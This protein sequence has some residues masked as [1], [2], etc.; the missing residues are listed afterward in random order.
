[1]ETARTEEK[2]TADAL[3]ADNAHKHGVYTRRKDALNDAKEQL[4]VAVGR[5]DSIKEELNALGT[6]CQHTLCAPRR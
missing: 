3:D 4:A 5:A 2:K 1:V 6:P